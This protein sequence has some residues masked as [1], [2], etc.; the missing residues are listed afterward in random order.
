MAPK[1]GKNE[2]PNTLMMPS[3]QHIDGQSKPKMD[4]SKENI[5]MGG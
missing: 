5:E 2:S 1:F 3:S 4:D